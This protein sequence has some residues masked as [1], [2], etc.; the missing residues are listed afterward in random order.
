V[1]ALVAELFTVKL[2]PKIVETDRA[3]TSFRVIKLVAAGVPVPADVGRVVDVNAAL[4]LI[5]AF[6]SL[7]GIPFTLSVSASVPLAFGE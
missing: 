3:S 6:S 1:S 4:P 2:V 7:S 5:V